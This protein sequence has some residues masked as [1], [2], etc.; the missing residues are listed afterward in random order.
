[1]PH[2]WVKSQKSV[3]SCTLMAII[4]LSGLLDISRWLFSLSWRSY[5]R[6]CSPVGS[7]DIVDKLLYMP[8]LSSQE[9]SAPS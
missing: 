2:Q 5:V 6:E 7:I 3:P 4:E 8:F 9:V 1:M